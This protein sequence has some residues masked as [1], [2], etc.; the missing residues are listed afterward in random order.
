MHDE[1][2]VRQF[3]IFAISALCILRLGG[4]R[5]ATGVS[6]L[7]DMQPFERMD[8]TNSQI[9][10]RS[11]RRTFS[12]ELE[13]KIYRTGPCEQLWQLA[14]GGSR[15]A[16]SRDRRATE[17]SPRRRPTDSGDDRGPQDDGSEG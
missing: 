1:I 9:G 10:F 13:L 15:G 12:P 7:M 3:H 14:V 16:G 2:S 4:L 17:I 8:G 6:T 5:Q 11:G